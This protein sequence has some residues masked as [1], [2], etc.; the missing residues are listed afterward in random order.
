MFQEG[1]KISLTKES[2]L[3][4]ENIILMLELYN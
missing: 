4:I 1:L 3:E 2:L